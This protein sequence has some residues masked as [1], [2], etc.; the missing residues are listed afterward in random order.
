MNART[1]LRVFGILFCLLAV[2]N[3]LKPLELRPDQGLVFFGKRLSGLPNLIL[4]PLF[5]VYL[6]VYGVGII[7]MKRFAL[8]M[9]LVYAAYVVV[10]LILFNLR[11]PAEAQANLLF[12][13]LYTVIAVGVS[14]GSAYLLY[15]NRGDLS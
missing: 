6:A 5:G 4:G 8:P 3:L 12:G 14:S 1:L 7:M 11:M 2:S 10:N 9:G 13:L 15:E